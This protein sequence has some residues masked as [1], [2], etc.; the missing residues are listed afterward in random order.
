[1]A[2]FG[3]LGFL[4]SYAMRVNL[5][6]AIVSMVKHNSTSK[7][8]RPVLETCSELIPNTT[9]ES[10]ILSLVNSHSLVEDPDGE[11]DWDGEDQGI[12]L[13]AF[14]WGYVLT[15]VPG[16]ILAE[17]IGGKWPFGL[18]MLVTAVFSLATP[19]AARTGKGA[20]IAVR[21]IQGFGEVC[22]LSW[23]NYVCLSMERGCGVIILIT[24]HLLTNN[25]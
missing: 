15:Q 2:L 25:T 22:T 9:T 18:G 3:F 13:G 17:R 6:L 5:S 8:G 19:F 23:K 20:L 11:F 16:G 12:I 7:I 10:P 21:I 4:V 14:F 24:C 1:M